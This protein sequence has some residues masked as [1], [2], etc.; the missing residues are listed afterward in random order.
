MDDRIL[1]IADYFDSKQN[2]GGAPVS[3]QNLLKLINKHGY[4]AF[5]ITRNKDFNTKERYIFDKEKINNDGQQIVFYIDRLWPIILMKKFRKLSYSIIYLNSFFSTLSIVTLLYFN[6]YRNS[7]KIIISSKGELYYGAIHSHN[8]MIKRLYIWF[9][10]VFLSSK[11]IFHF[12]SEDEFQITKK[13]IN[14]N[15]HYIAL[16]IYERNEF[17]S[18]E[19]HK[20][21]GFNII[22]LSRIDEKKNLMFACNVIAKLKV[23]IN[24]DIYGAIGDSDYFNKCI[25]ILKNCD[26]NINY[27]YN[28][29]L[30]KQD[31]EKAFTKYDLFIF[32]TKGEN[33]G[34]VI[35]ESL[36]CG[37]PIILSLNTTLWNNL[38]EMD[39]GFNISLENE[40]EW[41]IAIQKIYEAKMNKDFRYVSGAKQYTARN[42]IIKNAAEDNMKI[43]DIEYN[44]HNS[45]CIIP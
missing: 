45:S 24:F 5:V 10:N 14:I 3:L 20:N 15:K 33:F 11:A 44:R 27:S 19:S 40:E 39:S 7:K 1:V 43:F 42:T 38:Q 18:N 8:S 41:I 36:D 29:V 25:Q 30:N 9:F 4:K 22:F 13:Y 6:L 17:H 16:D 23:N 28:G 26:K 35:L 12:S 37:C 34:Y 32:P 2:A 31:A 21:N